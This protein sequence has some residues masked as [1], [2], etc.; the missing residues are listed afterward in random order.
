MRPMLMG[1]HLNRLVC[2]PGPLKARKL[3]AADPLPVNTYSGLFRAIGLV[4]AVC[5]R[6]SLRYSTLMHQQVDIVN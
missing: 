5:Y 4:S 6:Q 1:S 3:T 2:A